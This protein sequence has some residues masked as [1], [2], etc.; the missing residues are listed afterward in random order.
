VKERHARGVRAC[1]AVL[2]VSALAWSALPVGAAASFRAA[3][4]PGS[5]DPGLALVSALDAREDAL[6]AASGEEGVRP[7]HDPAKMLLLSL[8]VPG[9]GQLVQGEKRGYLYLLAEA[10][11]WGGFYALDHRG[12]DERGDYEQFADE[13]WSYAAY[14]AWYETNC[15][16]CKRSDDYACRPLATHGTQEYYEDI[17]KYKTYWRWWHMDGDEGSIE[18]SEWST[19]DEAVRDEYWGMRGE[20]NGD[21]R[22]ARYFMMAALLNHVVAAFDAFVSARRDPEAGARGVSDL[23]LEF[24]VPAAGDGLACAVVARY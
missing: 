12:L 11:F 4:P 10:A 3:G 16:E 13:H 20:S 8:V 19:L 23:G 15:V 5:R 18:W 2:L 7:S 17:G 22:H 21:L 9:S 1:A 24:D 6:A 14:T